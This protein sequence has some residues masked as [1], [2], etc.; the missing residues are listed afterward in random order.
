[1]HS[2]F[3]WSR[4]ERSGDEVTVDNFVVVLGVVLGGTVDTVFVVVD[5]VVAGVCV[6]FDVEL[7]CS[8]LVS[9]SV[10]S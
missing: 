7:V 5:F 1:M 4:H 3:S 8:V 6:D 2:W 10:D 9:C